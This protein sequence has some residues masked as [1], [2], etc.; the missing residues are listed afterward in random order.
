MASASCTMH[1]ATFT[2]C[3]ACSEQGSAGQKVSGV[4]GS[5]E[6]D[7]CGRSQRWTA[8]LEAHLKSGERRLRERSPRAQSGVNSDIALNALRTLLSVD[9]S[10][11]T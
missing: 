4:E 9:S 2:S 8:V 3:V 7:G 5:R 6:R 1:S 10:T 11:V